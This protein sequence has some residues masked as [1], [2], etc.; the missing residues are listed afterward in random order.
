MT[1]FQEFESSISDALVQ[2]VP[3][4]TAISF[5]PNGETT[6]LADV[7]LSPGV[8]ANDQAYN[9]IIYQLSHIFDL[10]PGALQWSTVPASG[11]R[12]AEQ[13][14]INFFDEETPSSPSG[15]LVAPVLVFLSFLFGLVF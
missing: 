2:L 14:I 15:H 12:S 6:V 7:T 3:E 8:V 1:R 13:V 9:Q 11:K 5:S 10:Y 4:I